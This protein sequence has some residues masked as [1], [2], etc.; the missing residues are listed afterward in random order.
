MNQVER[1]NDE[2]RSWA[3]GYL[4]QRFPGMQVF[5]ISVKGGSGF[6]SWLQCS[7]ILR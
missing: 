7:V 6:D 5:E 4:D 3:G 1:S 2:E